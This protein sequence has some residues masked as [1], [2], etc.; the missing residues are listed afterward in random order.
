M[1]RISFIFAVF[2]LAPLCGLI[3][4]LSGEASFSQVLF[5]SEQMILQTETLFSN[6]KQ[7]NEVVSDLQRQIGFIQ[8]SVAEQ[9]RIYRE[10]QLLIQKL[11]QKS[12]QQK[13]LSDELYE[14]EILARLGTPFEVFRSNRVEIKLFDLKEKDYKGYIA[15]VKVFD[16][17]AVQVVLAQDQLGKSE[18]TSEAVQRKGAVLGINGGGFYKTYNEGQLQ[19]WPIGTT[20]IDSEMITGFSPTHDDLFFTGFDKK[21]RLIGGLFEE[22]R[23]LLAL[24]PRDGVS[25]VPVLLKNREAKEIPEKWRNEKH[26]R[27]VLGQYANGDLIFLVIDGRQPGWSAGATLEEVQIKLLELGV[28]DAYNLDGGGSTTMVYKGKVLNRPSDGKERRVATNIVV[29]P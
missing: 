9:E 16:P 2:L 15:K 17:E 23:E 19:Y 6:M 3:W 29:L 10:Q 22:E 25:F 26:P 11:V 1:R 21:G 13:T 7:L 8:A 14:K 12:R 24:N 27:T 28:V 4:G 20:M 5:P 18:T